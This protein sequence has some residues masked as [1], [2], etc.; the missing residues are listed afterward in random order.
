MAIEQRTYTLAQ[1]IVHWLTVLLVFY[2]LLFPGSIGDVSD[3]FDAGKLPKADD[4]LS[5]HIHIYSGLAILILT[6]VRIALKLLQGTPG[7]PAGEPEIFHKIGKLS[8][9]AFYAILVL[10]PILGSAKY[11]FGIDLAGSLHGG[12]VKVLLWALIGL[13][14]GAVLVHQFYWKTNALARMTRNVP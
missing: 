13:H 6:L 4:L 9:A 1:R 8:H 2:N 10:M 5:A 14:V 7:K 3:T 12:P 11:F